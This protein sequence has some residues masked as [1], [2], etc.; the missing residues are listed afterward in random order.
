MVN[1][2]LRLWASQWPT[3]LSTHWHVHVKHCL[4]NQ[5]RCPVLEIMS[6]TFLSW[7]WS[8]RHLMFKNPYIWKHSSETRVCSIS[9]STKSHAW[10]VPIHLLKC[11]VLRKLEGEDSRRE[12]WWHRSLYVRNP[13]VPWDQGQTNLLTGPSKRSSACKHSSC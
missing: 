12:S 5:Q 3:G 6:S 10:P 4:F 7:L 13:R 11:S 2:N 1:A 9:S 8:P